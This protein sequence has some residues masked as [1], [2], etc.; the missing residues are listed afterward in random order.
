MPTTQQRQER[1]RRAECAR[2]A[3]HIRAARA[4]LGCLRIHQ[5]RRG[6]ASAGETLGARQQDDDEHREDRHRGEDAADQE[7]GGL[8][9][10]S[11]QEAGDDGAAVVAHAAQRDRDETVEGQHRRI[12]KEG[13]QHLAAGKA[14]KRADHAGECKARHAQAAFR[15]A[16][17][18][19]GKVV[20]GDRQKGMADQGVAIEQLEADDHSR[21]RQHRQPELLIEAAAG[22]VEQPRK[23]L[24]LRAPF[25]RGELLDHQRQRQRGEHVEMLVQALEHRPHG[26]DLG[27]DAEHRAAGQ[28]E[29]KADSHR[30]AHPGDEQRAQHAAEHPERASGEA[31]HARGGEHHIIGDGDQCV[32]AADRQPRRDDRFDHRLKRRSREP[33]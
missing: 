1:Q 17:C 2:S 18:A 4:Q 11:E 14:R 31:E 20:L 29:E 28:C 32:D 10:Q 30:Q 25:D 19:G 9:K 3:E 23:R 22:D 21:A 7:V 8:L 5:T 24:R 16:E 33:D 12:G 26:D 15:Q 13:Q 6:R 27:D